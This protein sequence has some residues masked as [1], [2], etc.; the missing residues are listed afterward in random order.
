MLELVLDEGVDALSVLGLLQTFH[1]VLTYL[2][3]HIIICCK[4]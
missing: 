2:Y 1:L 4:Q 3:C